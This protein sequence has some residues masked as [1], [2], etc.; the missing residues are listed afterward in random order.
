LEEEAAS[1]M[2]AR[3]IEILFVLITQY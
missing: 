2:R 1:R 3:I